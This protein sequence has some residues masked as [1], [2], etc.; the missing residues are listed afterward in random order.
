MKSNIAV[1]NLI[2]NS[3][4]EP[5]VINP[6]L[7]WDEEEV[8]LVD[9]G[10]PGQLDVIRN[11]MNKLGV[12]F[13]RLTKVIITHHDL[14]H[15]GSLPEIIGAA[16]QKIDVLAHRLAKPYIEGEKR[17]LKLKDPKVVPPKAHVDQT[18]EDDDVLPECGGIKV[19]FTP[20]HT[21][22]HISLYHIESKTLI[23]GD[24]TIAV[25]GELRGPN[26]Q[27][28]LNMKEAY[29]SIGKLLSNETN[30]IICY[31]GGIC[32][33]SEKQRLEELYHANA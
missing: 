23:A 14:D 22:D 20:G 8:V 33:G 21:P 18:V 17:L 6:T 24:A 5:K 30:Q 2:M 10:V 9:A 11:E 32:Q 13:N 25:N 27:Y 31:H 26:P 7:I 15:I 1:L 12:S 3:N 16:E 19:I 29:Q 4:G 28:T